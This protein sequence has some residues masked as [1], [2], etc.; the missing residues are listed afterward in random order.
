[1]HPG[2]AELCDQYREQLEESEAIQVEP[3]SVVGPTSETEVAGNDRPTP[4]VDEIFWLS[5]GASTEAAPS[6]AEAPPTVIQ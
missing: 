6:L 2:L 5:E 4:V 3:L 1:M